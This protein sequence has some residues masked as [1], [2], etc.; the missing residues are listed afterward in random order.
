MHGRNRCRGSVQRPVESSKCD[1]RRADSAL[2]VDDEL[3]KVDAAVRGGRRERPEDGDVGGD[4]E[5]Q[6]PYERPLSQARR[7]VLKLVEPCASLDEPLDGPADQPEQPQFLA[8]RRI[9]GKAIRVVCIALGADAPRRCCG[10]ATPHSRAAASGSRAM[11][12]RARSAPTRQIRTSTTAAAR[13]PIMP[14]RPPAM[15]S[16]EYDNGGPVMPRSK[17]RATVRS[18]ASAGSSRCAT[19]G[20]RTH[21]SVS[22]S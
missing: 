18:A 1:Q 14:T 6:T 22:R 2:R 15:K 17:S 19:P 4:D 10:R 21:I 13:P 7:L 20:G 9:D 11:R 16:I 8:R 12:L 5:Q 3:A